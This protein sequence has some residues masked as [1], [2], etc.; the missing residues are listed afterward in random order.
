MEVGEN[1]YTGELSR[2]RISKRP[3]IP[4][5]TPETLALYLLHSLMLGALRLLVMANK[6]PDTNGSQFFV[7]LR[8]CLHLNGKH[9]AFGRVVSGRL[10]Y[11]YNTTVSHKSFQATT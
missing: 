3:S 8:P 5:G 11:V 7:S 6:G 2:M 4:K 1:L 10:F 9:V